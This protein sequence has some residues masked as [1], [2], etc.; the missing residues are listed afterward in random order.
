MNVEASLRNFTQ[1]KSYNNGLV[2]Q[3]HRN[4]GQVS[5][6]TD[7]DLGDRNISPVC[8]FSLHTYT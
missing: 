7:K 4:K 2:E 1:H 5:S 8:P 3:I 6:V